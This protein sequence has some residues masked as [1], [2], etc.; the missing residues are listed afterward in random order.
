MGAQI[1]YLRGHK[2]ALVPSYRENYHASFAFVLV[3]SK[4]IFCITE[5]QNKKKNQKV[6]GKCYTLSTLRQK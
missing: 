3:N 1:S 5:E 2:A 6:A 4:V